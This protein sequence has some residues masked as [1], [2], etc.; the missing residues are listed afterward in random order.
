M[1]I[2]IRLQNLPWSAN[3][4]DIR[5]FFQGL[6]IP[7]GG[8]HIVGGEKGDAFIAFASDEDAR[9][10]MSRDGGKIREAQIKLF[11]SSRNEMQRVI[12]QARSGIVAGEPDGAPK[13]N[14]IPPE[15]LVK[16]AP[17]LTSAPPAMIRN[18]ATSSQITSDR[19]RARSRSPLSRVP[20]NNSSLTQQ[21]P[22]PLHP[23][24]PLPAPMHMQTPMSGLMP[25]PMPAAP[26]HGR[27]YGDD[28]VPLNIEVQRQGGLGQEG[29]QW[30]RRVT[31]FANGR[32]LED[33][34]RI[35]NVYSAAPL[36]DPR[37]NGMGRPDPLGREIDM[38]GRRVAPLP[39]PMAQPVF[40]GRLEL[41]GLP[42][43]VTPRDI[44]DFFRMGVGMY[45]PDDK[46]K[47]LVDE[48]G[49][50]TGGATVRVANEADLRSALELNGRLMGDR[51][52]T[53]MPL[54]DEMGPGDGRLPDRPPIVQPGIGVPPPAIVSQP[55][56]QVQQ[57]PPPTQVLPQRDY[58]IYMKGIPFNACT[59][60]DVSNFFQGLRITEIVFEMDRHTGK[61]AGNAFV[62]FPTREDYEGALELNLR[63]MGR[64]YI[65]MHVSGNLVA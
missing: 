6:S 27:A 2:I 18:P 52:I 63:H 11:L 31:E 16:H 34:N 24:Q 10:A 36:S 49:L 38:N 48:R 30:T 19:S 1:S 4:V 39:T 5:K 26:L 40:T 28:P 13:I 57:Q 55:P 15:A 47:I 7:D 64:R 14:A 33:N 58:V 59:D 17:P 37:A 23:R 21:P 45:I 53:V 29:L 51:C 25:M 9:Q 3:S 20:V 8:V 44:Q 42:F 65:G 35:D 41:R 50:T 62:E 56:P 54:L 22:P 46:V 12:E 32:S 43:N 60:R 61:P